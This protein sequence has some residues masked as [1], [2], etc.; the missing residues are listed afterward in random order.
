MRYKSFT[1]RICKMYQ[2]CHCYT[3]AL[4]D[5]GVS[6]VEVRGVYVPCNDNAFQNLTANVNPL[7]YSPSHKIDIFVDVMNLTLNLALFI[8]F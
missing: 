7:Q 8:C 1:L 3:P 6:I 5:D 4:S 2:P